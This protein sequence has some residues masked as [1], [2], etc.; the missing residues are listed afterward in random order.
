RRAL[1]AGDRGWYDIEYLTAD[2]ESDRFLGHPVGERVGRIHADADERAGDE[3]LLRPQVGDHVSDRQA[4]L[5][6]GEVG[7]L[8]D[9]EEP[10]S[11]L[12]VA[13]ERRR[14]L[15]T[16]APGVLRGHRAR[17]MAPQDFILSFLR[18]DDDVVAPQVAAL[19]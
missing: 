14:P 11:T 13:L 12:D 7:R 10:A 6:D 17:G 8:I 18:Q 16:H 3:E 2:E 1:L 9:R 19:D 5:M 15:G 4:E